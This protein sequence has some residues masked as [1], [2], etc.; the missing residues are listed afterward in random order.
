MDKSRG[1][2]LGRLEIALIEFIKMRHQDKAFEG[3][4]V[5]LLDDG[6]LIFSTAI[7]PVNSGAGLCHETG[8]ICRAYTE[9]KR[10]L[11]SLCMGR[12]EDGSFLVLS[13]CGICQERLFMWGP[14]TIVGVPSV[15]DPQTSEW[16]RL[17]EVQ[18]Y[19]WAKVLP[20]KPGYL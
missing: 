15:S 2:G 8:N 1:E 10:V 5:A 13:P 7:D 3:G 14:E 6:E 18:P 17:S 16:K 19:F 12:E 9:E 20:E 11:A 4:A